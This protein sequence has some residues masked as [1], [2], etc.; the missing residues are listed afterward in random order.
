[1]ITKIRTIPSG[2]AFVR[3]RSELVDGVLAWVVFDSDESF[4][5]VH[6]VVNHLDDGLV[7]I[8]GDQVFDIGDA[9]VFTTKAQAL[10]FHYK[11]G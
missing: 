1:L 11:E 5:P 2:A 4:S 10:A 7:I 9:E 8:I 6:E 3:Y